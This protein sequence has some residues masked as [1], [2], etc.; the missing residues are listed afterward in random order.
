MKKLIA[1]LLG[2]TLLF[3]AYALA[4]DTPDLVQPTVTPNAATLGEWLDGA[5]NSVETWA[6]TSG[7]L[8]V[9]GQAV[10]TVEPDTVTMRIGTS[11]EDKSEKVAQENA[12]KVINDVIEALRALGIEDTQMVTSGYNIT[13]KYNYSG[14]FSAFDGYVARISLRV[15]VQDFDLINAILDA[16]VEK[17]AND[18]GN[19]SFS[20]SDEG[21]VYRQ[22]LADA[23]AAARAKAEVMAQAS[24]VELRTL[25]AVR[26]GSSGGSYYNS[27]EPMAYAEEAETGGGTQIMSGEIEISAY[28]TMVYQTK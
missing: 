9:R 26:E 7:E 8:E 5:V 18:V 20:Y 6:Q 22:A 11:A 4:E 28:V 10:R 1:T 25:L 16:A 2:L 27:Y 19:I 14:R 15:T 3:G 12:N 23:I 13:R 21:S 17:G 24:G